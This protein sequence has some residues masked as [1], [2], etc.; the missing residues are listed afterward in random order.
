[1]TPANSAANPTSRRRFSRGLALALVAVIFGLG[2]V[3]GIL[4]THLFYAHQLRQ[5]GEFTDAIV[6]SAGARMADRLDLDAAQRQ[7]L[8]EILDRARGEVKIV[9]RD[10]IDRL[11]AVRA[12]AIDEL[13]DLLDEDQRR[14]LER[15]HAEEGQFLDDY[16]ALPEEPGRTSEEGPSD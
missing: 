15:I 8:D 5:P 2:V 6:S 3:V 16:L 12:Q 14:E 11:R 1:M 4:G 7:A 10:L 13:F 9:R